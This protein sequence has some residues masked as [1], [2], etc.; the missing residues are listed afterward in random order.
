MTGGWLNIVM[1]CVCH[2]ILFNKHGSL[3]CN[4]DWLH[5]VFKF[6][7][8]NRV[9][10]AKRSPSLISSSEKGGLSLGLSFQH[11]YM[12]SPLRDKRRR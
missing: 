11:S 4:L 10:A 1:S 2:Y 9:L 12:I 8:T 5:I 3:P 6:K 7:L